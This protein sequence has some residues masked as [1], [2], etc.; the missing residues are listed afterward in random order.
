MGLT[1]W[2]V[3]PLRRVI[4][5]AGGIDW[6][7]LIAAYLICLFAVCLLIVVSSIMQPFMHW[8]EFE[9]I[10]GLAA[11]WLIK[12]AIWTVI[13]VLMVSA[14]LS[15]FNPFSPSLPV[16]DALGGPVLRP[17]RRSI[18]RLFGSTGRFDYSPLVVVLG[19]YILLYILQGLSLRWIGV[20]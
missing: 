2:I 18:V 1:D 5:G 14:T 20:Y 7:S 8:P 15:W 11:I 12:W 16:F 17:V 6:S 10:F 3:K 19:L 4:P 13:V 9:F